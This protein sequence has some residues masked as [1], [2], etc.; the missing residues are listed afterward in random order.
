MSYLEI[1]QPEQATGDLKKSY[2][3]LV[4]MYADAGLSIV[5][6]N[7]YKTNAALPLYL[8]FGILQAH[9]LPNYPLQTEPPTTIPGV[10]VNFG[11]AKFSSC[12]Y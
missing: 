4:K 9:C 6:P 5:V 2:D 10:L 12:F 8:D 3:S 1:V 7:V 11:V